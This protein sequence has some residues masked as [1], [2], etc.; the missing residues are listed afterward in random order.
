MVA[1]TG[2]PMGCLD[3]GTFDL[4]SAIT[5]SDNTYFATV[6]QRVINNPKYPTLDSSLRAWDNYMYGFGL[7]I[8]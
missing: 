6:M 8:N 2:K 4:Q 5:I 7:A 3:Y 1:G